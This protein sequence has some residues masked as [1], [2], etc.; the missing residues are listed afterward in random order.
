[1]DVLVVEDEWLIAEELCDRLRDMEHC[2]IG[3]ALS[4]AEA[5][6]LLKQKP[7]DVA[8]L[9]T[10]LGHETCETVFVECVHRGIPVIISSGHDVSHLPDFVRGC[11]L[12]PK[13]HSDYALAEALEAAVTD[14]DTEHCRDRRPRP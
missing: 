7:A 6:E 4:C 9:D 13:P 11:V 8:I 1:V 14:L 12:L 10:E 2:P 5:L 3:P